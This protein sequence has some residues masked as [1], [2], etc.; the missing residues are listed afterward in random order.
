MIS[1]EGYGPVRWRLWQSS[2]SEPYAVSAWLWEAVS[3]RKNRQ[4]KQMIKLVSLN[5]SCSAHWVVHLITA[6]HDQMWQRILPAE[7]RST[8]FIRQREVLFSGDQSHTVTEKKRNTLFTQAVHTQVH[9]NHPEAPKLTVFP[10]KGPCFEPWNH[11]F[12]PSPVFSVPILWYFDWVCY[13]YREIIHVLDLEVMF[14][15]KT[16]TIIHFL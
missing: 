6:V 4:Q 16:D 7:R 1:D 11:P 8:D 5:L 2:G 3:C 10:R 14:C 15:L 9:T 13:I 12:R